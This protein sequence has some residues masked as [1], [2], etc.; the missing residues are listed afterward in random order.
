M[1]VGGLWGADDVSYTHQKRRRLSRPTSHVKSSLLDV[2]SK[3][4][5]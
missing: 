5:S 4:A 2:K 3:L 1:G